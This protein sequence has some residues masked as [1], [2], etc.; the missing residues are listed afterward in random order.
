MVAKALLYRLY[1][2]VG[3]AAAVKHNAH[4]PRTPKH[5]GR[6]RYGRGHGRHSLLLHRPLIGEES[7]GG[8]DPSLYSNP[9]VSI[10][11]LFA[12]AAAAAART[13]AR[14]SAV[15][16]TSSSVTLLTCAACVPPVS[17]AA[18]TAARRA[19]ARSPILWA[20]LCASRLRLKCRWR[21][22]VQSSQVKSSQVQEPRLVRTVQRHRG[23]P[24][25]TRACTRDRHT[26]LKNQ[27]QTN[28]TNP[29]R[30][31]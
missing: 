27:P 18:V 6:Y 16:P 8:S 5:G 15:S 30:A 22:Q 23:E 4:G 14:R 20:M 29:T 26:N 7:E 31:L 2:T 17:L 13:R 21:S 12:A 10:G 1:S 3:G 28:K 11:P 25:H 24:G 9:V 19:R